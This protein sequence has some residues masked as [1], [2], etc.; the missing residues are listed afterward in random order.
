MSSSRITPEMVAQ[1]IELYQKNQSCKTIGKQFGVCDWSVRHVLLKNG[2]EIRPR[3]AFSRKHALDE[4]VFD[5]I[6]S[7][8]KAYW[9]GFLY[10][11]GATFH[12]KKGKMFHLT[13]HVRD[14]EIV[15]KFKSF[16]KTTIPIYHYEKKNHSGIFVWSNILHDNLVK[17][18]CGHKKSLTLQW[19]SN[20]Q[21]PDNLM[22]HFIRGYFDGDGSICFSA[23]KSRC[24]VRIISSLPFCNSYSDFMKNKL[25]IDKIYEHELQFSVHENLP[26][27]S[28]GIGSMDNI[29]KFYNYIYSDSDELFLKRK[30][31]IFIEY[32]NYLEKNKN[33]LTRA[34]KYD[35]IELENNNG[36]IIKV[37]NVK[38]ESAKYG[39]GCGEVYEL[40]S[41]KRKIYKGFKIKTISYLQK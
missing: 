22:G 41:G 17:L 6:D 5:K 2:I 38:R 4:T 9:L 23:K 34:R 20:E 25:F 33:G 16:L 18:G 12:G 40:I 3:W 7:K 28:I 31:D 11:D 14:I 37:Y 26:Y 36:E 8:E 30:H 27:R 24:E 21:V 13:L 15:N 29:K 35:F 19:P 32:F 39:L 1:F 10:A